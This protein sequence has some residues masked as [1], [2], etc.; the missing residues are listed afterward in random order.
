MSHRP[1]PIERCRELLSYRPESGAL[2]WKEDR[3]R[4]PERARA[5]MTA[6]RRTKDGYIE[7]A[8]DAVLYK[9]HRVAF[10]LFHGID[11]G[12]MEIDHVNR[13]R[14]DNGIENLRLVDDTGQQRNRT[15]NSD[16]KSG[17]NGVRFRANRWLAEGKIAGKKIHLGSFDNIIDAVAER[18]RFDR[19]LTS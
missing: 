19:G 14:S 12:E 4:N 15:L 1:I 2:V 9:A 11:P 13:R 7:V 3:G 5:G 18:L 8:V 17:V 6:G 16:N 10:A